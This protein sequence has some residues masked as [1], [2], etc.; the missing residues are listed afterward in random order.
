MI[1]LGVL[2]DTHIPDRMNGLNPR[3][4]AIFHQAGVD[5]ILHAG[6]VCKRSVLDELGSLA[7]V[8]A[9]RGNRDFVALRNLPLTQS[10]EFE[11]VNLTMAHGHGAFMPYMMDKAHLFWHGMDEGRYRGRML[12]EFPKARVI[13]FGHTHLRANAWV[14]GRLLFNP[15]SACCPHEKNLSPSI[16]LLHIH[17]WG[18]VRGEIIDL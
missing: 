15:G 7:P 14:D 6:D 18:E 10:L 1:S 2:A 17:A 12:R 3:I 4:M 5:A 13:I 16:G 8:Y 11:G 9:V